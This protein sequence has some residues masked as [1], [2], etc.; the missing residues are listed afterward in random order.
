MLDLKFLEMMNYKSKFSFLCKF[1]R[2][3]RGLTY[4]I[5]HR[6]RNYFQKNYVFKSDLSKDKLTQK[7]GESFSDFFMRVEKV[8]YAHIRD[9]RISFIVNKK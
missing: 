6:A 5:E 1:L 7:K 9:K 3:I 8:R 2:E 4:L